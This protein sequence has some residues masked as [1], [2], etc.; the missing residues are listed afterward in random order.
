MGDR[1]GHVAQRGGEQQLGG[2][3]QE[4]VDPWSTAG[5]HEAHEGPL[6]GAEEAPGPPT[7]GVIGGAGMEDALDRGQR[8]QR[9]R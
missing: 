6:V 5:Q 4:G 8:P 9:F 2:G 1:R 7:V 3:S